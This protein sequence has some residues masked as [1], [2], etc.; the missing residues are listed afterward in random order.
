MITKK[1]L[2]TRKNTYIKKYQ[3]VTKEKLSKVA[4]IECNLKAYTKIF[5]DNC[6]HLLQSMIFP[7]IF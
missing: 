2:K 3:Q 1:I 4:S 7:P 5:V 6:P